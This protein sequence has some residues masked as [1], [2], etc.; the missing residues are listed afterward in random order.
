MFEHTV[1][2]LFTCLTTDPNPSGAGLK[3]IRRAV[4]L[5]WVIGTNIQYMSSKS[6]GKIGKADLNT[7]S[8]AT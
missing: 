1:G 6:V 8:L 4:R 2:T 5:P 3:K 7:I